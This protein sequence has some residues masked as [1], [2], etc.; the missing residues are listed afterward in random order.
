LVSNGNGSVW[1]TPL[2]AG[3]APTEQLSVD[4]PYVR[5]ARIIRRMSG[6]SQAQLV[7]CDDGNSYVAK[8]LGNPQGSRTLINEWIVSRL[9]SAMR[10]STPTLRVLEL[11]SAFQNR[12]EVYFLGGTKRTLPQGVLHL[13]SQCPVDPE[14]TAVFDFLPD[15]LLLKVGNL[16]EY[17]TMY[18][19]DQWVGQS[20][21]R[22][23]IFVRDRKVTAGIGFRGYFVDHGLAFDGERWQLLDR[24]RCG[25]AFQSKIYSALDLAA[26]VENALCQVESINETTLFTAADGVPSS[27][28]APGDREAL[29]T[30]LVK[31]RRRQVNLRPLIAR[32]LPALCA[33]AG[34]D[35]GEVLKGSAP[36]A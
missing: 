33:Y 7:Q 25:L 21:K 19:F 11:P 3:L 26:L 36:L 8:F 10:I 30:L 32:H 16:A 27:W 5:I 31:L 15:K 9:L 22:Q 23:A 4:R 34:A 18:V 35:P 13:G 6:G 2:S 20:D 28:F 29:D 12:D 17:A 14:K 1:K 24:P